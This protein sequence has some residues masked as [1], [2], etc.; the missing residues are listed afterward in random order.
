M[1][2][3]SARYEFPFIIP[4]QAQKELFHNEALV[5][6][7]AGL[8]PAVEGAPLDAPPV[9][10]TPGACWLIGPGASG[11]WAGKAGMLASWTASGWRYVRPQPGMTVWDKAGGYHRR[12]TGTAWNAGEIAG[13]AVHVGGLKVVGARQP[14]VAPPSGGAVVDAEARAA[15]AALIVSL[16]SHGLIE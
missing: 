2:E 5:I 16:K 3:T 14:S 6:I 10:P 15:V 4:G 13:S 7:D 8:H 12:W 9:A 11:A 1:D